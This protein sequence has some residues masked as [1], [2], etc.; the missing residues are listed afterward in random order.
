MGTRRH[1]ARWSGNVLRALYEKKL[2]LVEAEFL[3]DRVEKQVRYAM[4]SDSCVKPWSLLVEKSPCG[5]MERVIAITQ[6]A[7]ALGSW[8]LLDCTLYVTLEPCPMCAGAILQARIPQ[9]V[10]GAR[11]PKGGAVESLFS[12]VTDPRLNHQVSYRSGQIGRA[13]V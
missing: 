7:E 5:G 9:L 10:F 13:H 3:V 1:D 8:R 4:T 11:D 2:T 12:L 6:A